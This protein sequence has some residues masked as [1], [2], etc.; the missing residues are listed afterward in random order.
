L[1][2]PNGHEGLTKSATYIFELMEKCGVNFN[3]KGYV[4]DILQRLLQYFGAQTPNP[5][6]HNGASLG[7]FFDFLQ[8][9][10]DGYFSIQSFNFIFFYI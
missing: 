7:K 1:K 3:K 6:H 5:R 10:L 4:F 2:I 8:V 9:F